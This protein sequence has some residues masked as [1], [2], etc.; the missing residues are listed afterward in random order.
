MFKFTINKKINTFDLMQKCCYSAMFLALA[1]VLPLFTGQIQEIGSMLLPMHV[2][3]LFCG[4][5]CGWLYGLFV[6]F[7]APL[8]RTAIFGMP[9]IYP[10]SI[11]MAFELATHGFV[12]GFIYHKLKYQCIFGIYKALIPAMILGRCVWGF[13]CFTAVML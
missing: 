11:T 4:L 5:I 9:P 7:V 10:T 12:I 3:V 2:P 6:G 8:L 1:L 13:E